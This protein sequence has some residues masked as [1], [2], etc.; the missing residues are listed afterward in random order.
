MDS[1]KQPT[2]RYELMGVRVEDRPEVRKGAATALL[3]RTM[4]FSAEHAVPD[5]WFRVASGERIEPVDASSYRIDAGLTLRIVSDG[6]EPVI[7]EGREQAFELRLPLE[8]RTGTT[9]LV[10]EYAW[11]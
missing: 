4:S 7:A 2:F 9:N 10:L 11:E 6:P 5:L 1:Q 3:V 8:I